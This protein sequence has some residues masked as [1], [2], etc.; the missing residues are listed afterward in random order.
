MT[1]AENDPSFS[2]ERHYFGQLEQGL[3]TIP[4]CRDCGDYHF[5]PRTL[6][7]HC[8]S[9]ALE[10]AAPSGRGAV[11]TTTT[12]RNKAGDYNVCLIDLDEGPRLMSRVVDI[13]PDAVR[14]GMRVSARV[15]TV[16]GNPLLVFAPMDEESA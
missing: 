13:A 1:Q 10:W 9:D 4:K 15:D 5:F 8:G 6:C 3:F 14:V 2:P 12:V 7:P 11:Y 16:D